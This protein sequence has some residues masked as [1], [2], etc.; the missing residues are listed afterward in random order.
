MRRLAAIWIPLILVIALAAPASAAKPSGVVISH[1]TVT[2][3]KGGGEAAIVMTLKNGTTGPVSLLSVTSPDAGEGMIFFDTNMCQGNHAMTMLA[4]LYVSAGFTQK[5]GYK[6]QGAMIGLLHKALVVGQKIPLV[7]LWSDFHGFKKTKVVATVVPA[8]ATIK[9][10][11][12][13]MEM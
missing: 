5:F 10:V 11:M 1:V 12:G 4:N 8:P 13:S 2:A 9:F 7:V 3:A 6:F